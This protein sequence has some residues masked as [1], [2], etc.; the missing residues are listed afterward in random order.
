MSAVTPS[1]VLWSAR[2]SSSDGASSVTASS[3]VCSSTMFRQT[4]W[5]KRC[6]PT[7]DLVSHGRSWVMGAIDIS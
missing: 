6:E 5:S 4:R 7:T 1:I 2:N 3:P